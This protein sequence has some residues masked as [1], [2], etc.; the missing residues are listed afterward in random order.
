MCL[1]RLRTPVVCCTNGHAICKGCKGEFQ[2]ICPTCRQELLPDKP[3][4]LN[5]LIENLPALC[6]HVGCSVLGWNIDE[7]ENF[8][9]FKPTLCKMCEWKGSVQGLYNHLD[10][11][12]NHHTMSD[13]LY[14]S[15]PSQSYTIK[16][17]VLEKSNV[18]FFEDIG[19]CK[20]EDQYFWRIVQN[21]SFNKTFKIQLLCIPRKEVKKTNYWVKVE[22]KTESVEYTAKVKLSFEF[23]SWH[24]EENMVC[25]NSEVIKNAISKNTN[26]HLKLLIENAESQLPRKFGDNLKN[27]TNLEMK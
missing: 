6:K 11:S 8:C 22:F 12:L 18:D 21:N 23:H 25:F 7:H 20:I 16:S 15:Y 14:F 13:I 19:V 17:F 9:D 2:T 4:A 3:I 26:M 27:G 1:G 5:N 10:N 24:S